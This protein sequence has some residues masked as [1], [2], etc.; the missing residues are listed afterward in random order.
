M[1]CLKSERGLNKL[2]NFESFQYVLFI[3]ERTSKFSVSGKCFKRGLKHVFSSVI[4]G[5]Y[6]RCGE[7]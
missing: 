6:R 3:G 1:Q 4:F 7:P 2:T 5:H